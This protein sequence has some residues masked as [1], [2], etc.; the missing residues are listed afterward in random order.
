MQREE[1]YSLGRPSL[2]HPETLAL[3]FSDLSSGERRN[4]QAQI[5]ILMAMQQLKVPNE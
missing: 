3:Q 2:S 4:N 1:L 5:P